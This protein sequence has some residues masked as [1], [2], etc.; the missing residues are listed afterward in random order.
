MASWKKVLTNDDDSSYKNSNVTISDLGGGSGTTF[1]RRDGNFA[2]PTNTTYSTATSSTLGLVKIGYSENGQN[3]P[4]ELSSGK[5]YVNV[6]W[7]DTNTNATTTATTATGTD[8]GAISE[9][10]ITDIDGRSIQLQEFTNF[11]P[12]P[13]V[14]Y[15]LR[16]KLN[17]AT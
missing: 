5:M 15:G 10:Y 9:P 11:L 6:P 13:S 16:R 1:L 14:S 8:F 12:A 17:K 7:S 2:T 3:Y 4:V